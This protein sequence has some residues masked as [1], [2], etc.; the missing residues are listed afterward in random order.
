M[1]HLRVFKPTVLIL[2]PTA[3]LF[4]FPVKTLSGHSCKLQH[5]KCKHWHQAAGWYSCQ[6]LLDTK[7]QKDEAQSISGLN[8]YFLPSI[9]G[10]DR[11]S[12]TLRDAVLGKNL[13]VNSCQ[14]VTIR[15]LHNQH[16]TR[17]VPLL[18]DQKGN[19]SKQ[20]AVV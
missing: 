12:V 4:Q 20:P 14:C 2:E 6:K 1:E 7:S 15:G 10:S 5:R 11:S 8:A 17:N 19:R 9:A 16:L 18:S 3:S 13:I